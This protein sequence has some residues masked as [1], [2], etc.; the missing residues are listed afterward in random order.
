MNDYDFDNLSLSQKAEFIKKQGTFIEAQDF[1]SYQ[2]LFY[3][4]ENHDVELLYDF[5]NQLVSVE[6]TEKKPLGDFLNDQLESS[7]DET[8]PLP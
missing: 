5:T 1:Y 6:F 8:S 7:L 3:R 4:L 2:I